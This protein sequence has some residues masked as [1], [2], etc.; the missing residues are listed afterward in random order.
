LPF[1]SIEASHTFNAANILRVRASFSEQRRR[2]REVVQARAQDIVQLPSEEAI[3]SH[4]GDFESEMNDEVSAQRSALFAS[5]LRDTGRFLLIGA[6]ASIGAVIALAESVPFIGVIGVVGSLGLGLTDVLM[7]TAQR[8][9]A[10]N[11]LLVLEASLGTRRLPFVPRDAQAPSG[12]KTA[13][14]PSKS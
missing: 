2:F 8:K 12:G 13:A 14:R 5:T 11:Y 6:P 3:G 7:H 4:L 10:G 9:R 1:P